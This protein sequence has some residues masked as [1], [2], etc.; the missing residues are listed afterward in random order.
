MNIV[1][2]YLLHGQFPGL[3]LLLL[4]HVLAL[5]MLLID[6][7]ML[8]QSFR[9]LPHIE[10]QSV[11]R[12][13]G[14]CAGFWPTGTVQRQACFAASRRRRR[15]NTTTGNRVVWRRGGRDRIG[16]VRSQTVQNAVETAQCALVLAERLLELVQTAL[17][18]LPGD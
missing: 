13:A 4:L 12:I 18:L 10:R 9:H 15:Q 8:G 3:L 14:L 5:L 16:T 11:R 1:P 6:V 17:E 7:Q 2:I